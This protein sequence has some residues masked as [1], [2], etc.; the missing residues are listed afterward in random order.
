MGVN[1]GQLLCFLLFEVCVD[2]D[3]C[4]WNVCANVHI[5]VWKCVKVRG[6]SQASSVLSTF[7]FVS[8]D[9]FLTGLELTK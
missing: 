9:G 8:E 5:C 1:Q 7:L 4:A 6:Q 3:T 2:P